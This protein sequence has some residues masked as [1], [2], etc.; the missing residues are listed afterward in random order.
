MKINPDNNNIVL[1][2]S[3]LGL[4]LKATHPTKYSTMQVFQRLVN[5]YTANFEEDLKSVIEMFEEEEEN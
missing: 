1:E 3:E 5:V 2:E 4:L